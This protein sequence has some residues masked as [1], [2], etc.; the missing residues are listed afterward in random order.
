MAIPYGPFLILGAVLL[1]FFPETAQ[2]ML[3]IIFPVFALVD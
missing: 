1:L 2:E 3:K